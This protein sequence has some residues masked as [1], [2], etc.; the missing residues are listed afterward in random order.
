MLDGHF[1]NI[2]GVDGADDAGPVEGALAVLDAGGLE[3]RNNGKVLPYLALKACLGELL[4][5]DRVGFADCL[6]AVTRD[7]A[8]AADSQ[9]GAGERLSVDHIVR[10]AERFSDYADFVLVEE[11]YG[12]YELEVLHVFGEAA[13]VVVGLYAVFGFENV[14]IYGALAEEPDAGKLAGFLSEN[15]DED[16]ADYLALGLRVGNACES[17]KET[18]YRVDIYQVEVKLLA[19]HLADLLGLSL[20]EKAVV[21][22]H[23]GEALADRLGNERRAYGRVYAAGKGQQNLSVRTDL[24]VYSL[25]LF[26][27]KSF[28]Q[29]R[30]GDALHA[31]GSD[32]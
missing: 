27:N 16:A 26:I 14:R 13:D 7:R 21:Y 11:L 8:Y 28:C 22:M 29:L 1:H 9:A 31:F 32:I 15:V 3:V 20:A 19:E 23:A 18:V 4:A 12:L 30:S 5:E 24:F 17:V 2:S 25:Q 10:K 6:E